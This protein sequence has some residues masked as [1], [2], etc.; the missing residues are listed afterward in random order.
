MALRRIGAAFFLTMIFTFLAASGAGAAPGDVPVPQSAPREQQAEDNEMGAEEPEQGANSE[1]D[2]DSAAPA[3]E[4]GGEAAPQADDPMPRPTPRPDP[5]A[6][7][8]TDTETGAEEEPASGPAEDRKTGEPGSNDEPA[9]DG[10]PSETDEESTGA[11]KAGEPAEEKEPPKPTVPEPPD[12]RE[13]AACMAELARRG[14]VF[15]AVEPVAGLGG[16]GI[17]K[18]VRLSGF[19]SGPE[20]Q[21]AATVDCE[22]A[23]A[24][25]AWVDGELMPA[26][27]QRLL[28]EGA[29]VAPALTTI[30]TASSYICRPRNN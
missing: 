15:E 7:S 14:A 5:A 18:P 3:A 9:E 11:E 21:P 26:A 23:V 1:R 28:A 17:A 16:C 19:A 22:T 8:G 20:L 29:E 13:L 10:K 30:R 27:A 2:P 25:A 12:P 4:G 24:I 6:P